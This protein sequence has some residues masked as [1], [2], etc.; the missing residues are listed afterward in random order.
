MQPGVDSFAALC[1]TTQ[2]LT[3]SP[4]YLSCHFMEIFPSLDIPVWGSVIICTTLTFD[5]G[6]FTKTYTVYTHLCVYELATAPTVQSWSTSIFPVTSSQMTE[7]N[8]CDSLKIFNAFS[9]YSPKLL[10]EARFYIWFKDIIFFMF[11][12]TVS[13]LQQQRLNILRAGYIHVFLCS[14]CLCFIRIGSTLPN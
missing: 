2:L 4:P 9:E 12:R 1:K 10:K 13:L 7:C 8:R 14:F 11:L 5:L 3:T 6:R